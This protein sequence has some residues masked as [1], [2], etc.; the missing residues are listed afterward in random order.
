[1]NSQY[2][3]LRQQARQLEDRMHGS[4]D[5]PHDPVASQ[6]QQSAKS[7]REAIESGENPGQLAVRAEGLHRR[8]EELSHNGTN[9]IS[10]N[11]LVAFR[12]HYRDIHET[13][14]HM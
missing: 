11:D 3:Q 7:F 12:D 6:I 4:W 5:V 14:K 10:S 2:S 9:I 8:L 13:F 1:M